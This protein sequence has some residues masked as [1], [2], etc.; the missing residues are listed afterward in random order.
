M[1]S[2]LEFQRC[3]AVRARIEGGYSAP[4]PGDS[5]PTLWGIT[6]E[7]FSH[8][9]TKWH[10][11]DRPVATMTVQECQTIYATEFWEPSGAEAL[12]W[13]LSV[14]HYDLRVNSNPKWSVLFLQRY[15]NNPVA[16]LHARKRLYDQIIVNNPLMVVNQN[17]WRNRLWVLS[18]LADANFEATF[19]KTGRY[20]KRPPDIDR[21]Q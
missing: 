16:Y 5:H 4:R 7:T 11:P 18:Q 10:Q 19:V 12:T 20:P 6:Q 8:C 14:M 17:G 9:L 15:P 21:W 1:S 2:S 13:P 3:D